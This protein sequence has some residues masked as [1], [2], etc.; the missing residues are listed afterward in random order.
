M[1]KMKTVK[2]ILKNLVELM[3][4]QDPCIEV[5]TSASSEA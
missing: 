3:R 4:K 5:I 1:I 2:T